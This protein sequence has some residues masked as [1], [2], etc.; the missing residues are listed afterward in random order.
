MIVLV[1]KLQ[2]SAKNA[3]GKTNTEHIMSV[4]HYVHILYLKNKINGIGEYLLHT[5]YNINIFSKVKVQVKY[6]QGIDNIQ[7]HFAI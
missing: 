3:G 4:Y 5:Y 6:Q 1:Q 2:Y 7:S